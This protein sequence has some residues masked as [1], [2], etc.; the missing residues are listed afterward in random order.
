MVTGAYHPEIS[1]GGVQCRSMA[2]Q[3]RGRADVRVLTTSVDPSLP[4]HDRIDDVPVTR[5]RVDVRSELSKIRAFRRMVI[6]L[7]RLVRWSDVVHLHGYSTKNVIVTIIAKAWRKPVVMSLHTAGFDEPAVIEQ[8]GSL[9]YWA[10]LSADRYL[11]VSHGLVETYLAAGLPREKI[12]QVPN[13]IDLDRFRPA[14]IAEQRALRER[15]GLPADAPIIVCVGFFSADKQPRVLFDAWLSIVRSGALRPAL[16]FVG[17]TQS[18]YFE[19]DEAIAPQMQR[20]AEA[21]GVAS[22]LRLVGVTHDVPSYLRAADVFVLPSK[23]EGLPVALLEAMSCGLACIASRL[24]G[25][26]DAIIADGVNG[27]LC[28]PGDVNELAAALAALLPDR[29]R[30]ARLG[31]AA[32]ATIAAKY[33]SATVADRWLEAYDLIP[34]VAR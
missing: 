23:R 33:S 26:T 32:R 16:V 20:D 12:R 10:F 24:P 2:Q 22:L 14:T 3:L 13:G 6:D 27:V 8:Q 28:E 1:S 5:I 25:S 31:E 34:A 15:L 7:V 4:R 21:D 18:A 29:E 11:S 9:A 17:A 19:I 30:R